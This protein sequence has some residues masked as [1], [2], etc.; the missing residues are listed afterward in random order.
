VRDLGHDVGHAFGSILTTES[1]YFGSIVFNNPNIGY[2]AVFAD[3]PLDGLTNMAIIGGQIEGLKRLWHGIGQNASANCSFSIEGGRWNTSLL[4]LPVYDLNNTVRI[5]VE[6]RRLIV[7]EG[8]SAITMRNVVIGTGVPDEADATA[9]FEI[10]EVASFTADGCM[11]PNANMIHRINTFDYQ[12]GGT[13]MRGCKYF[14][15]DAPDGNVVSPI[16]E[17]HGPENADFLWT[18][19]GDVMGV[20]TTATITLPQFEIGSGGS[21]IGGGFTDYLVYMHPH[22]STGTPPD[23][24][25]RTRIV[26]GSK[27]VNNFGVK[28][29]AAPGA[30]NTV[31]FCV[32]LQLRSDIP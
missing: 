14:T 31:T 8:G 19:D 30:G 11:F 28:L 27:R 13:Y 25:F 20:A 6:D 15:D 32:S 1:P 12:S 10:T 22:S 9:T 3:S 2:V 23:G 21:F 29:D 5:P 26:S 17:R 16:P 18:A 4:N 7:S 24:A